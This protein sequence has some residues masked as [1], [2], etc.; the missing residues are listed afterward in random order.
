[1]QSDLWKI[2]GYALVVLGQSLGIILLLVKRSRE[3]RK[4]IGP[5]IAESKREFARLLAGLFIISGLT[6]TA[7]L[8]W[9]VNSQQG[10]QTLNFVS[11]GMGALIVLEMLLLILGLPAYD[12]IMSLKEENQSLRGEFQ[13]LSLRHQH[14]E[15]KVNKY[16][17]QHVPVQRK[18]AK[19]STKT[20]REY[21]SESRS[22]KQ[23]KLKDNSIDFK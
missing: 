4:A 16:Q 22:D 3:T 18:P 8:L 11:S 6:Y 21:S 7:L 5:I 15:E 19:K 13:A 9:T 20:R 17:K 1:M 10:S 2:L 23:A 14:L 12:S